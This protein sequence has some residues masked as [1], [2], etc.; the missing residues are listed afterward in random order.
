MNASL[1]EDSDKAFMSN[2]I[3]AG[4]KQ[5]RQMPGSERLGDLGAQVQVKCYFAAV[6]AG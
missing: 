6:T 1:D 2:H 4:E 5:S 3:T